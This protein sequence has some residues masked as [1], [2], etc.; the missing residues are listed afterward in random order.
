MMP[1]IQYKL[2]DS[3]FILTNA[4]Q[5]FD[6]KCIGGL[7]VNEKRCQDYAMRSLGIVTVLNPIIGYSK[8][9]EVVKESMRTGKS[10]REIVVEQDFLS[11]EQLD[12]VLSPMAMTEPSVKKVIV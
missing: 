8:A 7:T 6:E 9:S 2:L 11:L 4:A 5:I 12:Q 1:L 3:V 10:V